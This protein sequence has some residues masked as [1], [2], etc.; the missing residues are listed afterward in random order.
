MERYLVVM[1]TL[2]VVLVLIGIALTWSF[3]RYMKYQSAAA[4][5]AEAQ[6]AHGEARSAHSRVDRI[7]AD[8]RVVHEEA[9]HLREQQSTIKGWV[10]FIMHKDISDE[11]KRQAFG[12][13]DGG[14]KNDDQ[15]GS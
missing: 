10:K 14:S 5:M 11:I 7:D 3:L 9:L 8:L 2:L 6:R 1:V 12:E 15:S 13:K 4:A